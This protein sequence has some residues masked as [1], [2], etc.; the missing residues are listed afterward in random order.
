MTWTCF[1]LDLNGYDY[2]FR[3]PHNRNFHN[4]FNSIPSYLNSQQAQAIVPDDHLANLWA[5][6][7][8]GFEENEGEDATS[9][10][11]TW[12]KSRNVFQLTLKHELIQHKTCCIASACETCEVTMMVIH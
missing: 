5:E 4:F 6:S 7:D 11:T 9:E 3:K 2:D 8:T 12:L 10:E 1:Y